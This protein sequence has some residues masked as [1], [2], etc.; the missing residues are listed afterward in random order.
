MYVCMYICMYGTI[1]EGTPC[2]DD[3]FQWYLFFNLNYVN[4]ASII[5]ECLTT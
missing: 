3:W 1:Q 2:D 5:R 4:R